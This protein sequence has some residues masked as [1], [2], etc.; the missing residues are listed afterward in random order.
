MINIYKIKRKS[1]KNIAIM[2]YSFGVYNNH[3]F[4]Y[5]QNAQ[6]NIWLYVDVDKNESF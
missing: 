3:D 6:S 1:K 2:L 5:S 4:C